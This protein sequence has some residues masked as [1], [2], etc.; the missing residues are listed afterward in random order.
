MNLP[1][2]VAAR[3]AWL[4]EQIAL[5]QARRRPRPE[6]AAKREQPKRGYKAQPWPQEEVDRAVALRATGM[7]CKAIGREMGRTKNMVISQM[8]RLR[9]AHHVTLHEPVLRG[10][11]DT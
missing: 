7:T 1:P 4:D 9:V 3:L 6:P 5:K 10:P 2:Q 11:T 8:R